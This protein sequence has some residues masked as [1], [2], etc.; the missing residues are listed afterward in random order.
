M[1]DDIERTGPAPITEQAR[2]A[3]QP[4]RRGVRVVELGRAPQIVQL[5]EGE[6]VTIAELIRR[7][8]LSPD[9]NYQ[10]FINSRPAT[11]ESLIQDGDAVVAVRKIT[12]G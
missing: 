4:Q 11:T 12:A 3:I 9:P 7:G 2:A 1:A 10:F 6:R 8:H 5:A